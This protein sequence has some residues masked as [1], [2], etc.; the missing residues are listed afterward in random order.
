[1][2]TG[3]GCDGEPN[4]LASGQSQPQGLAVDDHGVYWGDN[5]VD[6]SINSCPLAGCGS[7]PPTLLAHTE[8][9][10][11]LVVDQGTLFWVTSQLGDIWVCATSGCSD[12][13]KQLASEQPSAYFVAVYQG[14]VYW[15]DNDA[16]DGGIMV[17]PVSGPMSGC[18]GPPS[19]LANDRNPKG[20]AVDDS[21]VYWTTSDTP[22]SIR[23]CPLS[24]CPQGNPRTIAGGQSAP[25]AIAVTPAAVFWTNSGDGTVMKLAKPLPL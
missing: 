9:P 22:G 23:T 21:G 2:P 25:F 18:V 12:N 6:G 17:C 15:T 11:T 3:S 8:A 10:I 24:G 7:D 14:N 5:V 20:I 4:V 19:S 16:A 1:M 13:P